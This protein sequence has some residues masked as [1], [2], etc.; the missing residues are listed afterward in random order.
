MWRKI[1]SLAASISVL[2]GGAMSAEA[3][4]VRQCRV[5]EPHKLGAASGGAA[6]LCAEVEGALKAAVPGA[7]YKIDVRV[8]SPARL[9]AT[10]T[11]NGHELPEQNLASSDRDVTPAAIKRFARSIGEAAK[12]LR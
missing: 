5:I 3:T 8:V 1:A 7:R 4:P 11:I 10:G 2:G 9:A 12:A 6:R